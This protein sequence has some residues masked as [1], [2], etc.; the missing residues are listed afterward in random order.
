MENGTMTPWQRFV[1]LL[2][3]D[4][5]DIRQI[6]FYAI[7]AGLVALSLP[8][9][10]QAIIN[11][12]QGA[13]LSTSWIVL[14]ILVTIG[15]GF[16]GG[17]QLMQIR[18]LENIQQKIFMRSSFEFA[19]RFPKI[20]MSEI[21]SYYPPELANRFFDTLTVQKGLS[22]VL[23][24][25]PA[26]ALQI[27]F[28]LLL[29]SFYHPFFIIYGILL[30][31]LIYFLFRYTAKRG[32]ATS[33]AESKAKY[34]VAHWIQE[35]ARSLV[36]FKLSG[37]T[38]LAMQ[39]NDEHTATY[40]DARESHFKVLLLQFSQM[41]GFKVLVTAGLLLIGGLLVINQQMNIGQFVAAE[42]IILLLIGSV[43]KLI[44]GLETFYDI[45]TSLEKIGQVVDK[46][47]EPQQG[48]DP[49]SHSDS[50]TI[51]L[52]DVDYI[53]P[54]GKTI[55]KDI[56]IS[57]TSKERIVLSG[58]SGSG[59]TTLLKMLS[60]LIMPTSGS[61]YINDNAIEG[62]H[63]NAFRS[64]VGQV[65]PEQLPF[66]G[67]IME[68]ITLN[69][70]SITMER[71]NEVIHAVGLMDFVKDQY[72]GLHTMMYPEGQQIPHTISKRIVLARAIINEP[73]L[74]LLKDPL[75]Y[76]EQEEVERIINYL[77][78]PGHPWTLIVSSR[79]PLWKT[80]CNRTFLLKDKTLYNK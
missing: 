23:I 58:G 38:H 35:I 66:E 3:L 6:I 25:F 79:N 63:T 52:R 49:L 46:D 9:G 21:R 12:I 36:S 17:L 59:K 78:A 28:G 69:D 2:K 75:E 65:L 32:L 4:R 1:G 62:V 54:E 64:V 43:E 61:F 34:K 67:T 20:K 73:K 77:I 55:L 31:A 42:I 5:R 22:K 14:V 53:T 60:G 80:K 44:T 10:I 51:E 19:Y 57:F 15:V 45:L 39:R 33:L 72:K 50:L 74:L 40:L 71:L 13:Q 30:V 24:D 47:L 16:Q 41:I 68:N 26:A 70:P 76:F 37:K 56:S 11:L 8:L 48:L 29:L 18:I 27:I 7:F